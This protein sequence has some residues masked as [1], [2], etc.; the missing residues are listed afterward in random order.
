MRDDVRPRRAAD[1]AAAAGRPPS[2]RRRRSTCRDSRWRT[3]KATRTAA[4]AR[5]A[6][7]A[8]TRPATRRT[9][10]TAPAGSTAARCARRSERERRA[11]RAVKH[12]RSHDVDLRGLAHRVLTWGDADAPP[13]FLVHGWMDVAASFQFLVDAFARERHVVAPDLRGFGGSAW[14]PQGYW[15]PDYVADLE[16]LIE[17]YAPDR[18]VDI[19]G[20]SLGGNVAMIYAGVRPSRVR[21]AVSLEGFGLPDQP[22]RT[23]RAAIA[24]WLDAL[25]S[26]P[27][28]RP[29]AN[30]AAVADRLQKDNPRLTR[31][32]AVFLASHGRASCPTAAPSCAPIRA[33]SCRSR[34]S[35]G[36]PRRRRIWQR[37][38]RARAVGRG[39]RSRTSRLARQ[40]RR[41]LDGVRERMSRDPRRATRRDRRRRPHAAPRPA[42]GGRARGRGV[43][44]RAVRIETR[45][46]AYVALV[47]PHARVGRE[48]D[49]DEARARERA[50]GA[51]HGAARLARG[52]RPVRR[53]GGDA[54]PA[55]RRRRRGRRSSS[56]ASSRRR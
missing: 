2:R 18:P 43:P 32:R 47:R 49:R 50:P 37:D 31:E 35:T 48:L 24:K 16:A 29:Y 44:R 22:P 10:T 53:H 46:G 30:L 33:T 28:F 36:S 45:R 15:F 8:A 26:P 51:V 7:S 42:R 19:V 23:R 17:R 52:R 21:R 6:R 20:H 11:P 12:A 55:A 25:A 1:R 34:P 5:P 56:P 14:Q 4:P 3:A 13:L 41:R 9:A 38:H 54:H 27:S 39:R 40:G